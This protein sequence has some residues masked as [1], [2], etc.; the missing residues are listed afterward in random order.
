[1][2]ANGGKV[3]GSVAVP[4]Y[5]TDF[6]SYLLRAKDAKPDALFAFVGGG[7]S[8]IN[9]TKQFG[10]NGLKSSMKLIGTADL[11]S[12]DLMAPRD[13]M[14]S[15]GDGVKLYCRPQLEAQPRL[16]AEL[17]QVDRQSH[18]GRRAFVYL[19]ASL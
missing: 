6:S 12:E 17:S 11:I 8:S 15:R 2:A 4:L 7:P 10:T 16:R 19:G 1:M 14:W 18:A 13:R 5:T 3:I 9:I